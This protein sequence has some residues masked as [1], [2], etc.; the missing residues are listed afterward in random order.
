MAGSAL[1]LRYGYEVGANTRRRGVAPLRSEKEPLEEVLMPRSLFPVLVAVALPVTVVAQ[2]A[3]SILRKVQQ[4]EF[5]RWNGVTN[6]VVDQATMGHR[7]L[8]FY[9]KT[10]VT[11]ADGKVYPFFRMVTPEEIARRQ[12]EEQD[13]PQFSPEDLRAFS[14]AAAMTGDALGTE[15]EREM[16][17]AG[18]PPGLLGA[19]SPSRFATLDPR[20]MMGNASDFSNAAA[21][22][23]AASDNRDKN[24]E[25]R[26]SINDMAEFVAMAK[27]EGTENVDGRN[28]YIL[29]ADNINQT[30]RTDD[31]QEFTINTATY[32][33][34]STDYV[35][36][37][38]KMEGT[39]T[40]G[41]ETR[42]IVI[43]KLDQDY[44]RVGSLYVPYR[45][46]MRIAGVMDAEQEAQM[47]EAQQQMAELERQMQQM[48]ESQRQ[49]IMN[50]M[51]PQLEM[52]KKMASG[53]G[54]E[55][56]TDVHEV[57]VNAGLPNQVTLGSVLFHP[58]ASPADATQPPSNSG[59]SSSAD[60]TPASLAHS[61]PA[62]PPA[63]AAT[64]SPAASTGSAATEATQDAAA[65]REAQQLCLQEK[66]AE[67][68]AAQ[69][70][71][72]G[73]GRLVRAVTRTASRAG[74]HEIGRAANDVYAANATADDL[75]AAAKDLGLTEDDAAACRN[76]Q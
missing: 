57:R 29:R 16:Q 6:Y 10:E 9:E 53:G 17:E 27:V 43:E 55:L 46:I 26:E 66:F 61:S 48:P 13:F 73:V 60:S 63:N 18:L 31:G 34:D 36:L 20:I 11:A 39:A 67:A 74:N 49:M 50:T 68:Q 38:L 19:A 3:E 7:S 14:Q 72:R 25:G 21:D 33:V 37:R 42:A 70:K 41:G 24:T 47:Q 51:G 15:T 69:K 8:I 75:S 65:L 76:P 62:S 45:Q 40:Q 35:P 12:G 4:M 2:D 23:M 28:A 5:E 71:K 59:T 22:A 58:Q 56:I 30:Q 44:R 54:I 1:S 52:M 32:W 64:S